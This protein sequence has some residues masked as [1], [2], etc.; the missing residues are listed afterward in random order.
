MVFMFF[1]GSCD[2]VYSLLYVRPG[3]EK[4]FPLTLIHFYDDRK[5]QNKGKISS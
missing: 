4:F 1:S 2:F 5:E 3:S